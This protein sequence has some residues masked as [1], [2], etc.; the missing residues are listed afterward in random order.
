[1]VPNQVILL[2][3]TVQLVFWLRASTL[4][5]GLFAAPAA[6]GQEISLIGPDFPPYYVAGDNGRMEGE[7]V[8]LFDQIVTHA[9]LT[10]RP[11]GIVPPK[12]TMVALSGG[13]ADASLLVDNPLLSRNPAMIRTRQPVG[14]LILNIYG[15][16][17]IADG[18]RKEELTGRSVAV[19]RG[20]G[21][22]GLSAWLEAPENGVS[23]KPFDNVEAMLLFLGRG[24]ADFGVMYDVNF[25]R[26]AAALGAEAPP[27][28]AFTLSRVPLYIHLNSDTVDNAADLLARIEASHADLVRGGALPPVDLGWGPS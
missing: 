17:P 21:Y 2:H 20:Y 6:A 26:A 23:V 13:E 19:I 1:M 27:L 8:A 15:R 9:G 16:A 4:I 10:W 11:A 12:R 5:A 18:F 22:G 25:A 28:S 24:R 7:L 3:Q 14:A